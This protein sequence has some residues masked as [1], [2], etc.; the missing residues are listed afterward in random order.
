MNKSQAQL[1]YSNAI[2]FHLYTDDGALHLRYL[3]ASHN[4]RPT[5][6]WLEQTIQFMM[7]GYVISSLK[8]DGRVIAPGTSATV[9]LSPDQYGYY[10]V[11]QAMM[12]KE[13]YQSLLDLYCHEMDEKLNIS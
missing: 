5:F 10:P 7:E 4:F 9:D 8:I 1:S 6:Q 11:I 13:N 2:V 3:D 12:E